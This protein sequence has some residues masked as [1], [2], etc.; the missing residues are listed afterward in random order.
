ME[1][2]RCVN[3]WRC[4]KA[5]LMP[6][7]ENQGKH[8]VYVNVYDSTG[9]DLRGNSNITL[10]WGWEGQKPDEA[11]T[12]KVFDKPINEYGTNIPIEKGMVVWCKVHENGVD[13][14]VVS[15]LRTDFDGTGGDSLFH[16]SY[17]LGFMRYTPTPTLKERL[18]SM[19]NDLLQ[20]LGELN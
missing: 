4:V 1:I 6:P 8:N 5:N 15:G 16:H 13:S 19:V 2:K 17:I 20:L 14:D 10:S 9:K 18:I 3:G 11:S 7:S 12:D